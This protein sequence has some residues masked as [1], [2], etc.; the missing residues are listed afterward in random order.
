[1]FMCVAHVE[2]VYSDR[3]H[4]SSNLNAHRVVTSNAE[5]DII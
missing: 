3:G 5:H 2:H 4:V 1:M